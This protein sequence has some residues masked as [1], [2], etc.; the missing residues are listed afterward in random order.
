LYADSPVPSL[1]FPYVIMPDVGEDKRKAAERFLD[2]LISQQSADAL[3]DAGF[4]TPDGKALRDRSQ[5]KRTSAAPM[6]PVPLPEPATVEDV[7]NAW[8]AVNLSGRVLMLIDVSGSMQQQVPGTDL[9]RMA[10]TTDAAVQM[11]A[12]FKPTTRLGWWL[13]STK[14]DGA[15]DYVEW[16]PVT[17][18]SEQQASGVPDK[19]RTIKA[20]PNGATGLYDSA[21]AA[22]QAAQQQWEPGRI[23]A[24]IIMTDG[25]NEDPDGPRLDQTLTELSNLR[26]PRRPLPIIGIGIGPDVDAAELKA[27]AGATGGREFISTDPTKIK[28]VF[29]SALN[30][31]LCQPPACTSA[32][33]GG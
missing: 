28:D 10:V 18:V 4:R 16:L 22:Y 30:T 3:A 27:L 11:L 25:R 5:D 29:Y 12:L 14:L 32:N 21:L 8:A 26:D 19:L 1:D 13:F 24:V 7:L 15:R 2:R 6:T 20:V 33:G 31:V 9:T 23:N 17:P